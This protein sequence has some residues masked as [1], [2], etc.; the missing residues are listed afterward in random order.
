MFRFV[1]LTQFLH[2]LSSRGAVDNVAS[3]MAE[4]ETTGATLARLEARCAATAATAA[5]RGA[6]DSLVA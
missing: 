1:T 4:R 2:G 5:S 3:V 6:V